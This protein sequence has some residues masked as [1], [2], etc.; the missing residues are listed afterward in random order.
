MEELKDIWGKLGQK[1]NAD[2]IIEE[3]EI[4]KALTSKSLGIIGKLKG[5]VFQK[6]T[7]TAILTMGLLIAIPFVLPTASQMLMG[8]LCI[9][10]TLGSIALY[11]EYHILKKGVDMSQDV[12]HGLNDYYYRI[13]RVIRYEEMISL[14]LYP[15]SISAGF[16][17]GMQL[18]DPT[19]AVLDGSYDWMI[20]IVTMVILT[21]SGDW[22]TKWLNR[23][24]FGQYL[25][26]LKKHISELEE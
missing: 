26:D 6:L 25:T 23:K 12:L 20:L 7:I 15:I 2:S 24:A 9:A 10:Y 14:I 8:V 5:N 22:L 16:L 18:A 11:K 17:L 4:R 21:I 1:D 19:A 13:K 3:S